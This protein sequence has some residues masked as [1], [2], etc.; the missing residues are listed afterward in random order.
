M[1]Y[2]IAL[3]NPRS[4]RDSTSKRGRKVAK[5][6]KRARRKMSAKQLKYF[7]PRRKRG[8]KRVSSRGKVRLATVAKRKRS[9]RRAKS[10]AVVVHRA[11]RRSNPRRNKHWAGVRKHNRRTNPRSVGGVLGGVTSTLVPA[12]L[13]AV[14]VLAV[15][16][17][18]GYLP[19]QNLSSDP[20]MQSHINR[21]ARLVAVAGVGVI[22]KK[23]LGSARGQDIAVA[24][25]GIAI[26]GVLSS[27]LGA[28]A[29]GLHGDDLGAYLEGDELGDMPT[30][31]AP[32][33]SGD[34]LNGENLNDFMDGD[35]SMMGAYLQGDFD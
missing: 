6:R 1:S 21:A 5:K 4:L 19:L 32:L 13:G 24:A 12:G 20:A 35:E 23:V 14:G 15:D 27:F 3:V 34:N 16:R 10:T 33:L 7:G 25:M 11:K 17:V 22:A 8:K 30:D 31:P 9:K 29:A 28:S 26:H 2:E 18:I